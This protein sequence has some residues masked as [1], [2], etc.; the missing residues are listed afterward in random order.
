MDQHLYGSSFVNPGIS[1]DGDSY[2]DTFENSDYVNG[3]GNC[4]PGNNRRTPSFAMHDTVASDFASRP[5]SSS[6]SQGRSSPSLS[7]NSSSHSHVSASAFPAGPPSFSPRVHHR[8]AAPKPTQRAFAPAARAA[9]AFDSF[10]A[11]DSFSP[12]AFSPSSEPNP[13]DYVS[14]A[15]AEIGRRFLLYTCV[16]LF[17][18]CFLL[19]L[20]FEYVLPFLRGR[21]SDPNLNPNHNPEPTRPQAEPPHAAEPEPTPA[22]GRDTSGEL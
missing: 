11:A 17:V 1:S 6:R 7:L 4:E 2:F 20:F 9:A 16:I 18:V 3:D 8:Q 13:N 15:A 12:D 5:Q 21:H 10:P 19:P 14:E 22:T